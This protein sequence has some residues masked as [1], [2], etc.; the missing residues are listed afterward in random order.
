LSQARRVDA[1]VAASRH[2]RTRMGFV[3]GTGGTERF[4]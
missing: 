1:A 3:S 2:C 4:E